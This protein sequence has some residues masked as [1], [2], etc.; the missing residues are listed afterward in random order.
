MSLNNSR[1]EWG[2]KVA[3][4][5]IEAYLRGGVPFRLIFGNLATV[6]HKSGKLKNDNGKNFE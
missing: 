5:P 3:S 1:T 2:R 4:I 6:S